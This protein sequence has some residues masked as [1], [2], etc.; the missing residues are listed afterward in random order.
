MVQAAARQ[1]KNDDEDDHEIRT[2]DGPFIVTDQTDGGR[3][4]SGSVQGAGPTAIG[5]PTVT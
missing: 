4:S 5:T 2:S 1:M 3:R